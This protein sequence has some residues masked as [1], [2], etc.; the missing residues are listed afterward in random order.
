MRRRWNPATGIGAL[1]AVLAMATPLQAAATR[2]T[3]LHV[4]DTHSHLEAVGP[5]TPDLEGTVGGLAKAATVIATVRA[6][7]PDVLLLHAG[8]AFHGDLFFN[9]YFGVPELQLMQQL[10]FDAMAVGNHEFDLGPEVLAGAL[11]AAWG[12]QGVPLLSA[13]LDLAG[14]PDLGTWITSSTMK[15]V[16]GVEIGIFGLTVPTDPMTNSGP[17]AILGGDDP[18]VLFGIAAQQVSE[19]RAAGARVVVCLSHLGLLYDQALAANVPGIDVIVGGHDHFVLEQ[20]QQVVG[21]TGGRTL[22]LQAGC[23]YELVGALRFSVTGE[24]IGDVDYRLLPVD[25]RVAPTAEI[26]AVVETLKGGIFERWGDVYGHQVA[27]ALRDVGTTY[28]PRKQTR[29]TAIGDLVTD[30]LRAR[31]GTE[32]AITANGL[33]SEGIPRGP[34][35]PA[36]V[37]R[38]VSYGYDLATGLGF[39]IATFDITGA[40]LV[41]SLET[42]LAFLEVNEDYFLQVSGMRFRYD[43][44]AEPGSRVVLSSLRVQGLPLDPAATYS[45]TVDEGAAMLIPLMGVEVSNLQLLPDLEYTVLLD[46]LERHPLLS[47]R[48]DG[49]IRDVNVCTGHGCHESRLDRGAPSWSGCEAQPD[50]C[51]DGTDQIGTQRRGAAGSAR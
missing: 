26:Q 50:V 51:G 22:I 1:V 5:R 16:G 36:D 30:A 39:K 45:V 34:V 24:G 23:N 15:D 18:A 12:T 7:E 28:D 35:V 38:P 49:R 42:G 10:G 46:H 21:P 32:I 31:T 40:E 3:L 44:G 13:N 48:P 14:Y 2:I 33:I 43:S 20:P 9:A 8:D 37:F 17:V 25:A 19:L 29:D 27:Y 47:G 11:A 4:N 41:R 6:S